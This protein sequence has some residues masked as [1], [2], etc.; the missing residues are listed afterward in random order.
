LN[1]G[2]WW[3]GKQATPKVNAHLGDVTAGHV[4]GARRGLFS[5]RCVVLG[6]LAVSLFCCYPATT[7]LLLITKLSGLLLL[8]LFITLPVVCI[9]VVGFD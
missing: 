6:G 1:I 7:V 4:P 3:L 8:H 9:N 2:S 5:G